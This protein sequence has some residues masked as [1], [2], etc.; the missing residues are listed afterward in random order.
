MIC[1]TNLT[2]LG[3][4][5]LVYSNDYGDKLPCAGGP[6]GRWVARL[7][8]W[9]ADSRKHAY[10]LSDPNAT[11]GR[12][13]ISASLYLLVKYAQVA[14]KTF[15]CRG[16]F[17]ATE[18]DPA[19]YGVGDG[20]LTDLWDFG[21]E[22]WKHCSFSYHNPYGPYALGAFSE[23][24]MA[25]AAD[26]NPWIASPFARARKDFGKFDPDGGREKARAGNAVA[27]REDGQNVL[28]LDSHV[29]FEKRSFC[30]VKNDNVYTYWDGGDIRRGAPPTLGSQPAG[31]LDSLLVHDPPLTRQK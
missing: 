30:G 10:G 21:P 31:R 25:V 18:F 1:G 22:P 12:A 16:D 8:S 29:T 9:A 23:P 19:E 4:A 7:P 6:N 3:M 14:P 5:M 27:H 28:F 15:V 2:Y 17:G 11:D 13:T 26:R 20:K 24:G